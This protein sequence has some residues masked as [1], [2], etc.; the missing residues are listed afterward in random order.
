MEIVGSH[1]EKETICST[2]GQYAGECGTV[3]SLSICPACRRVNLRSHDWGPWDDPYSGPVWTSLFP[4]PSRTPA[5]LPTQVAKAF[6]AANRVRNVDPNAF[7]VL[8]GRVLD[9]V[10]QDRGAAGQSLNDRLND[11]AA[12]GEIPQKLADMA[13][14]LRDL[15]NVGAHA[16][17]GEL[18]QA[19]IPVLDDL[20]RAILE[21]VYSAP[22]LVDRVKRRLDELRGKTPKQ[23]VVAGGGSS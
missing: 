14:R 22:D 12:K 13:Q 4:A 15:R 1:D 11:L 20:C 21:Y 3:Y 8:L 23:P 9:H 6:E 10:C 2:D 17:L 7:A 5:A 16:E 19:E 18:T